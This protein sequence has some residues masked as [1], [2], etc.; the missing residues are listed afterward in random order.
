MLGALT[1][2]KAMIFVPTVRVGENVQSLLRQRGY[3]LPFYHARAG[4]QDW[5]DV[6]QAR[7]AGDLEPPLRAVICT[8]AFGMGLDVP[9]VRLVVHWQH[10]ASVEDYLQEFGRAGR[11]GAQAVAVL[12]TNPA[13]TR[14]TGLLL[15]MARKTIEGNDLPGDPAVLKEI[16]D[17]ILDMNHRANS[18]SCFRGDLRA[19]LLGAGHRKALSVRFLEWAFSTKAR[20]DRA[21]LCCDHCH[22][23]HAARFVRG[24]YEIRGR[25]IVFS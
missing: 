15:F 18:S 10:P 2:G 23:E 17:E 22:S 25:R 5:R 7:F 13:P 21:S 6:T 12:L 11:D 14:D 20:S 1:A 24:D 19:A 3:E 4:T 9:D 16:E 8:N